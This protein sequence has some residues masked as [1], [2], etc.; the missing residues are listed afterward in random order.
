MLKIF[1]NGCFDLLHSGHIYLF[2]TIKETFS[3]S[4]LI[5]GLNSDKSI[6]R[7]KGYNRP[8]ISETLRKY[9]LEAIRYIDE[10][11][12]FDEDTPYELIKKIKPNIIVKG[13]DYIDSDIIGSD[14]VDIGIFKIKNS[15]DVSTTK[16][17]NAIKSINF[18]IN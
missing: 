2:K 7:I 18:K 13:E 17:I 1:S 4:H 16:I 14:I 12:I 9:N 10:V 8:I 6:N 3:E 5:I 11:I 15:I